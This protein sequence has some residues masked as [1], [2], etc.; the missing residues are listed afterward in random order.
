MELSNSEQL[1][2]VML[3]LQTTIAPITNSNLI[4]KRYTSFHLSESG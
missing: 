1:T 3:N 4:R 2:I